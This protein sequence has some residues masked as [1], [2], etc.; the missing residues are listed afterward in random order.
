MW[1]FILQNEFV[2]VLKE[3]YKEG[4]LNNLTHSLCPV[5]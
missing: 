1:W 2:W 4:I 3:G 5:Y